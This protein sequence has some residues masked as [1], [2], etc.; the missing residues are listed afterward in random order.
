MPSSRNLPVPGI[1]PTSLTSPALAAR[2]F[3]TSAILE[4]PKILLLDFNYVWFIGRHKEKDI[5]N[6][7]SLVL[8]DSLH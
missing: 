5:L 2:F 3:T 1:E 8:V 4:A 7:L 6:I